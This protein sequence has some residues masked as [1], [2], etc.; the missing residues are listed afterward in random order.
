MFSFIYLII[1]IFVSFIS[2]QKK[3]QFDLC[4]SGFKFTTLSFFFL[5]NQK[6]AKK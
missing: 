6:I 5:E 2:R 3:V 4:K 1:V